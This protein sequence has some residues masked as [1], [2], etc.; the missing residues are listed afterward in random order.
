MESGFKEITQDLGGAAGQA[1][2]AEAVIIFVLPLDGHCADLR[3]TL[4][5]SCQN[6]NPAMSLMTAPVFAFSDVYRLIAAAAM[7]PNYMRIWPSE[8]KVTKIDF[9]AL[10]LRLA[11]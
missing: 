1:R 7:D 5:G 8:K 11:A 4:I 6:H 3:F 2:T 10:W 9:T